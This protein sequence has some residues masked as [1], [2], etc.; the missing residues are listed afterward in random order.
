MQNLINSLNKFHTFENDYYFTILEGDNF[1][2]DIDKRL[3]FFE[4]TAEL[5]KFMLLNEIKNNSKISQSNLSK[6]VNVVP[7]MINKYIKELQAKKEIELRGKNKKTTRYYLTKKGLYRK[8]QYLFDYINEILILYKEIKREIKIKLLKIY[9]DCLNKKILLYGGNEICEMILNIN[10]ELNY[11]I[12]GVVDKN[13]EN[14]KDRFN[15]IKIY[16]TSKISE[17]KFDVLII[18]SITNSKEIYNNLKWLNKK[19]IIFAKV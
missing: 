8:Q 1:L 13:A 4:P 11:N 14:I 15:E 3:K 17:L 12:I 7:A 19:I 9:K 2:I 18:T 5:R 16:N 10:K 6:R